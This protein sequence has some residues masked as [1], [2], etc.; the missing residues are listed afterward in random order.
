ME[1]NNVQALDRAF[2]LLDLVCRSQGGMT[3]QQLSA[4]TGL[5]KSTVHRMLQTLVNWRYV[6]KSEKD[7]IY[8]PGLYICELSEIIQNNM[9]IVSIAKPILEQLSSEVLETVHLAMR[10]DLDI[11]YIHKVVSPNCSIHMASRIGMHRPLYCTAVGKAIIATLA[12]QEVEEIWDRSDI[13][14]YTPNTITD[15]NKFLEEIEHV[16]ERGYAY[17]NEEN[18]IGV[19]CIATSIPLL[20]NKT[21]YAIS[22][23]L[24][25]S[26]IVQDNKS[27]LVGPL[28]KARADIV[29]TLGG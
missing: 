2:E 5:H 17:D 15:K 24:P 3:I 23:S 25:A 7:A 20:K 11:V 9:D 21:T 26:R 27:E 16:R 29:R 18:E 10:D 6:Q 4:L 12:E 8:R 19:H 13:K 22:V 1:K 14:A 28:M